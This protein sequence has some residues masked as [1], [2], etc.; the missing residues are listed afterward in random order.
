MSRTRGGRDFF[1]TRFFMYLLLILFAFV[2][3]YPLYHGLITSIKTSGEYVNNKLMWPESPV[4][5]NYAYV[6]LQGKMLRYFLNN[7]LIMP[8][9]II[10]YLFVC[11][12]AGFAFGRLKF[13]FRL[14]I[15]LFVLFLMIFPQMLLSVQIFQI[16]RKLHLINSYA[17]VVL[18][19]IAYFAPFGTYIMSTY[20]SS[21]PYDIIESARIDGAGTWV[22]LFRI[23]V[24]ISMAMMGVIFIIGFQ[25]M[26]NELP[27]SLLLLQN[28]D[29]RTITQGIGML[30]GQYGLDDTR[31]T[32]AVM[33]ASFVP[34]M[35]FLFF[36][37]Y[38][39]MGAFAGSV[40]G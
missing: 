29:M 36:Q 11:T 10:G 5:S 24:P 7:A 31:L 4:I 3:L 17:G 21:V 32:A 37:K 33:A 39:S 40:K 15:F 28:S 34:L 30:Q 27:F 23:M 35:L 25:S 18:V 2:A 16:C 22:I 13:P 6:L 38:I 14:P 9:A 12:A 8:P 26:W 20:F 1:P 19:W